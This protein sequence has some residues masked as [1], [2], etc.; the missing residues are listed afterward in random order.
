MLDTELSFGSYKIK[1]KIL[2]VAL[3]LIWLILG[4]TFA[5]CCRVNLM[6]AFA[7]KKEEI[8]EAFTNQ[9]FKGNYLTNNESTFIIN[10]DQWA[11]SAGT[12]PG[13]TDSTE[14][15]IANRPEQ[16]F[17]LPEGQLDIFEKIKFA[18]ECCPGAY[19][20]GAGCAC[21][22][23]N[24]YKYLKNRGGNNIPFSKF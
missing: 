3:F 14:A 18:P 24:T 11:Y 20:S 22:D 1:V 7:C 8:K 17:P 12:V 15:N 16:K 5:S 6:E 21:M 2:L 13:K 23:M 10:P 4:H 19:T 9:A